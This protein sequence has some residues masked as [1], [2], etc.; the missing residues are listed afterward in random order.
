MG[1]IKEEPSHLGSC[2]LPV[3]QAGVDRR[4]D[5]INEMP[6]FYLSSGDYAILARPRA[7][8]AVG[9]LRWK[10]RDDWLRIRV[11][12]PIPTHPK[13]GGDS[14]DEMDLL[15]VVIATRHAGRTLFPINEWPLFVFVCELLKAPDEDGNLSDDALRLLYWGELYRT[16]QDARD[17]HRR[18]PKT[19][20]GR[21]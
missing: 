11:S 7:C 15:E 3:P 10:Q 17:K 21:P 19:T 6:I 8:Y 1:S 4:D 9:R 12:P 5:M 18:R 16:E 20:N 2:R 14:A 13:S